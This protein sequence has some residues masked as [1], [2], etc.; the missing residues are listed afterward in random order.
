MCRRIGDALIRLLLG[1]LL[2]LLGSS[3]GAVARTDGALV[4]VRGVGCAST[5]IRRESKCVCVSSYEV[6]RKGCDTISGSLRDARFMLETTLA[7][8]TTCH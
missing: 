1:L 2:G 3:P 6:C 5:A 8:S 4:E 7:K